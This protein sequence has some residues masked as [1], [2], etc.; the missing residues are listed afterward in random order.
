MTRLNVGHLDRL[1][2]ILA[3]IGLIALAATGLIGAWG[4]LGI[5]PLLTG[6]WA[7]CPLY[8][9]LGISSCSR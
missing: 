4:Y 6:I 1:L 8:S 3:G 2:R 9:M 5:V 7:Y